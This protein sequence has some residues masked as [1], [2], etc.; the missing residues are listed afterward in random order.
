MLHG[1]KRS[2]GQSSQAQN[3]EVDRVGRAQGQLVGS[4]P[5]LV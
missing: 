4:D 2:P 1:T 5:S 3:S